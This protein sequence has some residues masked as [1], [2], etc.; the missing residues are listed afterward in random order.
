MLAGSVHAGSAGMH[1]G[2]AGML[3]RSAG[4]HALIRFVFAD[5]VWFLR[6]VF[7]SYSLSLEFYRFESSP[8]TC[9]IRFGQWTA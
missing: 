1:A 4:M 2:S 8:R 9:S 5:P 6:F 7:I 3:A